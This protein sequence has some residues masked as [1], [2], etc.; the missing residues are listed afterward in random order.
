M[1]PNMAPPVTVP[2]IGGHATAN[3]PHPSGRSR[4]VRFGRTAPAVTRK[5]RALPPIRHLADTCGYLTIRH[6][7]VHQYRHKS[8]AR[9]QSAWRIVRIMDDHRTADGTDRV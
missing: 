8:P 9:R 7:R 5:W 6:Y 2:V 1:I 3:H 4:T